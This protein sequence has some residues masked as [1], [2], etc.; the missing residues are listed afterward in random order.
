MSE[1]SNTDKSILTPRLYLRRSLL[2]DVSDII[3]LTNNEYI[4]DM[5]DL[6]YPYLRRD[7]IKWVISKSRRQS[8]EY[9]MPYV[10]TLAA[11]KVVVGAVTVIIQVKRKQAEIGYWIGEPYWKNGY[12]SEA[13]NAIT[14][15]LLQEKGLSLIFCR[16]ALNNNIS[17]K[18]L[19]KIGFRCDTVLMNECDSHGRVKDIAIYK[20]TNRED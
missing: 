13:V 4:A 6:P 17:I 16:V 2:T 18:I 10:I 12:A 11:S 19:Q 14:S 1:L 20:L 15:C 8:N 3:E 5:A 7:A 9:C